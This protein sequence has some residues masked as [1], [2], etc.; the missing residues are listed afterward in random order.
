MLTAGNFYIA[1]SQNNPEE[2]LYLSW[3]GS[4]NLTNPWEHPNCQGDLEFFGNSWV[5]ETDIFW[6]S[7]AGWGTTG[8]WSQ[9][10]STINIQSTSSGC[11]GSAGFPINT[12]YRFFEA[13]PDL[14]MI[15]RAFE[16]GDT[17][18]AH[19]V[20]PFIPRLY[21]SDGFTQ[22]LHPNASGDELVVEGTCDFG[23]IAES[24]DGSWFAIHNPATGLGMIVQ[25]VSSSYTSALWLDDDDGSFTNATSF[26]LLQPDGGFTGTVME[27]EYLC[28][29]DSATWTPSLTLPDGCQP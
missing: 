21:P 10:D 1:W 17:S 23:C 8:D 15:Q 25:R 26:L 22:V 20:R 14:I 29:Y 16:L 7:L 2:V 12:Q 4:G 11:P 5:T 28:F 6:A 27:T 24:W 19:D 18:Y 3:K 9:T 13:Q